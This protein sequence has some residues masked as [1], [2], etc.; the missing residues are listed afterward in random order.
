MNLTDDD[1]KSDGS[2]V[3][4]KP[5][6]FKIWKER[7]HAEKKAIQVKDQVQKY[8]RLKLPL[9]PTAASPTTRSKGR[10]STSTLNCQ[11]QRSILKFFK[12]ENIISRTPSISRSIGHLELVK[13]NTTVVGSSTILMGKKTTIPENLMDGNALQKLGKE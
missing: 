9:K 5:D 10:S 3:P 2:E 11:D 12:P 6:V 1:G 4:Q 7:I 13:S 8:G